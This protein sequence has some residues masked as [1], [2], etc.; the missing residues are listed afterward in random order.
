MF[1]MTQYINRANYLIRNEGSMSLLKRALSYVFHYIYFHE[2]YYVQE[3]FPSDLNELEFLP[4]V[5]NFTF[6]VMENNQDADDF[7]KK[8]GFDFR[9]Q[10]LG[11]R[12]RLAAGAVAFCIFINNQLVSV[13]WVGFNQ[14]AKNSF[15]P[16]PYRVNFADQ[17]GSTGGGETVPKYRG[18]GLMAYACFHRNNYMRLHGINKM[19]GIYVTNNITMHKVQS[20]FSSK[21]SAKASFT[22]FFIWQSWKETPLPENFEP[23]FNK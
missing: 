14:K 3:L 5:E 10:I 20:K 2:E 21:L 12:Q 17:N 8:N 16:Q 13:L 23:T 11:A 1:L 15:N 19:T 22:K 4:A 18:K 7:A 6:K 9:E